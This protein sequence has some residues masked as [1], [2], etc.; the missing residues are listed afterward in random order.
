SM[1]EVA[2]R[3]ADKHLS[4][5]KFV[6]LSFDDGYRDNYDEAF[7]IC[8]SFGVPMVFHV[9]TGFVRRT[10][11]MWWLG[12]EQIVVENE[13]LEFPWGGVVQHLPALTPAQKRKAY[14]VAARLLK[15]APR[16]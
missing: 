9:T 16:Q 15:A 11:P 2:R 6:C 13:V 14:G 3:L 10:D 12:L 5:R 4:G 7:P 1:T 8:A